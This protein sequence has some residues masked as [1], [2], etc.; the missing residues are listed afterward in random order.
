VLPR[1]GI[2]NRNPAVLTLCCIM[3]LLVISNMFYLS[4][5]FQAGG[6]VKGKKKEGRQREEKGQS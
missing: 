3:V 4:L 5:S 2:G 6:G 1:M